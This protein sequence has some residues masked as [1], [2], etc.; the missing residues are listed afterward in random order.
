[1]NT[2]NNQISN[3]ELGYDIPPEH[4]FLEFKKGVAPL[5]NLDLTNYK[6]KQMERR[7][8]SLMNKTGIKNLKEYLNILRTDK[9]KLDEF[10]NM[11]TINVTEFFRNAEKFEELKKTYIPELFR[12]KSR[13][14]VWSAGCSIGAEIYTLAMIFNE[15][16]LFDKCEFIA[17]DF[18]TTI[19]N[20]AKSAIYNGFEY[21]TLPSQ[22]QK[23]FTQIDENNYQFDKSLASRVKFEKQDLLNAKFQS[24]FDLILC[25][26]VVIYFTDES[27]DLLYK[28]FYDSLNPQG[29]MFIGSTERINNHKDIGFNLRSSF[30]YQK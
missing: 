6:N 26:N 28:K 21:K 4:E 30:F 22:Y 9:T 16:G 2:Q 1:M 29:I 18:D 8:A 19:L 24:G 5:I 27:K 14:K 15:L 13:I 23:Y 17:S 7:I 20:R 3:F 12:N 10:L 11:L 25:R